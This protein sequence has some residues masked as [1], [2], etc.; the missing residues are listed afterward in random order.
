MQASDDIASHQPSIN[1]TSAL[2]PAS[3][4]TAT[5][6]VSAYACNGG[7]IIPCAI[8]A[9]HSDD[10]H[11]MRNCACGQNEV[12]DLK[13]ALENMKG[14]RDRW[15]TIAER[16]SLPDQPAEGTLA[17]RKSREWWWRLNG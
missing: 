15:R 13:A 12:A 1:R 3:R 8:K 11:L 9:A 17:R 4:I 7:C 14:E 5:G 2:L 10:R 16:K 6:N